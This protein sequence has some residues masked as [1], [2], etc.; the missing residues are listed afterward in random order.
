M[1]DNEKQIH[2]ASRSVAKALARQ[3]QKMPA[4]RTI[5]VF[6]EAF[7]KQDFIRMMR[8]CPQDPKI[9]TM[10]N[11]YDQMAPI[12]KKRTSIDEMC[13]EVGMDPI[14]LLKSVVGVAA[15][16]GAKMSRLVLAVKTPEVIL[17]GIEYAKLEDGVS[18]RRM[19]YQMS[20][21][22]P[23]DKGSEININT[24]IGRGAVPPMEDSP[25]TFI[26]TLDGE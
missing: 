5:D 15:E 1:S 4:L 17:A 25:D 26:G 20:G 24:S 16:Y 18:D 14:E 6:A 7:G 3:S 11:R 13:A 9:A 19:I 21:H 22:M 10:V 2:K 8:L 12:T 23:F